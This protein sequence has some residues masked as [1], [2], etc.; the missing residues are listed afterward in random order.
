LNGT[1]TKAAAYLLV[2]L[3]V[4]KER[5]R[6]SLTFEQIAGELEVTADIVYERYEIAIQLKEL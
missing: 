2:P 4:L 6:A 1:F 5:V 3:R